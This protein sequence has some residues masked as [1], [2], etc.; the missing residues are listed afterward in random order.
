MVDWK[1][2]VLM[3][4]VCRSGDA[5]ARGDGG[6]GGGVYSFPGHYIIASIDSA[7]TAHWGAWVWLCAACLSFRDTRPPLPLLLSSPRTSHF[8]SPLHPLSHSSSTAATV[9]SGCASAERH[10]EVTR[11]SVEQDSARLITSFCLLHCIALLQLSRQSRP[12]TS[13]FSP[14]T[15]GSP[16]CVLQTWQ[17][18]IAGL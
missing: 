17:E 18:V 9:A 7:W 4:G 16:Y 13:R 3:R 15:T 10:V 12:P 5:R 6:G 8:S 14:A 2:K 1:C 11:Q